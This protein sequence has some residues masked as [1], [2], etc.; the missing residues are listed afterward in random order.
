MKF[1]IVKYASEW[2]LHRWGEDPRIHGAYIEA[3]CFDTFTGRGLQIQEFYHS[4]AIAEQDCLQLNSVNP[5]GAYAVCPLK[6]EDD[7]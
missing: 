6:E 4:K 7:A 3:S 5:V 2:K 1:V